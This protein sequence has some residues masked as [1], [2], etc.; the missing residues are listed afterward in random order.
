MLLPPS[1]SDFQWD[2]ASP[3]DYKGG[4]QTN[5]NA[6]AFGRACG[7]QLHIWGRRCDECIGQVLCD[8]KVAS[9]PMPVP[10]PMPLQCEAFPK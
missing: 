3:Q 6:Y 2:A 9:C 8:P 4:P 10:V 5:A 7:P 1:P